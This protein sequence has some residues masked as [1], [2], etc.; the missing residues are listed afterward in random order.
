MIELKVNGA[1]RRVDVEP[2]MPLLWVLRDGLKLTGTKCG[3]GAG[4]CGACTVHV[5][6]RAMRSCSVPMSAVKGKA[7]TTIEGL[8][9]RGGLHPVQRAWLDGQVPQC[10]YCQ[11]GMI[12]AVAALLAEKPH[13]TDADIDGAIGNICRCSTYARVRPAIHAAARMLIAKA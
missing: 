13:P 8:P 6:G 9:T 11:P 10:G 5:E 7:I 2:E 4:L 12:M 1:V 3:C